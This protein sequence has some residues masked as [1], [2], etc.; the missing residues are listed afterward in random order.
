MQNAVWTIGIATGSK[1]SLVITPENIELNLASNY[2]GQDF[3]YSS[4]PMFPLLSPIDWPRWLAFREGLIEN[5][6]L[7]LWV[8]SDLFPGSAVQGTDYVP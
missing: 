5:K 7:I 8:R 1:P 4:S 6:A 2:R 3:V